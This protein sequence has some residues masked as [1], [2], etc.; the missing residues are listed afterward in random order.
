M[1]TVTIDKATQFQS[2]YSAYVRFNYDERIVK[3]VK[4]LPFRYYNPETKEWEIPVDK[5]DTLVDN[6]KSYTQ[7]KVINNFLNIKEKPKDIEFI[8]KTTPYEHQKIGFDYGMEHSRWFLGDEQGLGKTKLV[9]DIAVARKQQYNYKHCLIV[10]GVN[11]L[12][13]NWVNEILTHSNEKP[14]ILG[15]KETRK[16]TIKI[17]STKDKIS[18]L[19]YLLNNETSTYFL[20]TNIESFRDKEFADMVKKLCVQ[21]LR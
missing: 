19:T 8:F 5:V 7:V 1:V 3:E 20:I 12:K 9:I 14:W 10:C 15:Q 21:P 16:G 13:W 17:G 18:D 4:K 6:L 11:T 2:V